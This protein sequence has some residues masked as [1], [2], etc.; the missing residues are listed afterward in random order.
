MSGIDSILQIEDHTYHLE[1]QSS[2][3]GRMVIR[4]FEYDF[5]IALELAQ[6][7]NETFEIEFPQSCVLY[8]RNHRKRSLPDY[9]EAIVKF[10]DGQQIVYRV[11]LLRAQNYT[12]DSIFEKRLLI[13]LPYHILRYESFLKNS[14]SNSKKLEQLLTDYQK[15]N[16]ALEQCTNDK[17]S[18][19]YIDMIALI[20]EI[21]DYIIPKDNENVRER[22]GDIMGGK[23]LKL[24]S[25][26]LL[27]KGQLL[28]EAKGRAAGLIQGQAEGR[29]TERIEAIQNMIKYDVSKEKILQD[30]SEEE[31]NEAIKSMLVEA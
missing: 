11:P 28:G 16:D 10:A 23:I 6:K 4:M 15:I 19:L 31:Y 9:H 13:L 22:L 25:E 14:G 21:A 12:V 26:R 30:Y 7:N 24:E 1:C 3:D 29:K 27:E 18:T 8:I 20:E 17:K 2:L 5:S